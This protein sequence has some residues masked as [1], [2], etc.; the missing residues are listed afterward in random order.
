M[1]IAVL[2][3]NC[4]AWAGPLSALCGSLRLDILDLGRT[5]AAVLRF[6]SGECFLESPV[7]GVRA[8]YSTAREVAVPYLER[9]HIGKVSW[10]YLSGVEPSR[11]RWAWDVLDRVAV[12]NVLVHRSASSDSLV[13]Q[14]LKYAQ[15]RGARLV[16]L[17]SGDSLGLDGVPAVVETEGHLRMDC[18]GARLML[19]QGAWRIVNGKGRELTV[20][21]ENVKDALD[22]E[23]IILKTS[24]AGAVRIEFKPDG[25]MK[26]QSMLGGIVSG[27]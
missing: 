21:P 16:E 22:T 15:S 23:N 4:L 20:V 17:T 8:G 9:N 18:R 11:I 25:R 19:E 2:W 7:R 27:L 12:R 26:V 1:L 3:L 6:P 24:N 10:L 14:F 13:F 5:G